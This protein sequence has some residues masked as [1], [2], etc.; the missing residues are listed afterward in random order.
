VLA[1]KQAGRHGS[2]RFK[3]E[4]MI[5]PCA[6]QVQA[7]DVRSEPF[8]VGGAPADCGRQVLLDVRAKWKCEDEG[9][10]R[11][12]GKRA[13]AGATLE[14]HDAATDALLGTVQAD[15]HGRFRLPIAAS[16]APSAI[17]PVV[18]D[19]EQTWTVEPVPVQ[20]DTCS[21]DEEVRAR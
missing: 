9:S 13:L 5:P 14:V 10:L 6:V 17:K 7:G 18:S 8:P 15:A 2:F 16:T 11:V 19:G 3:L 21:D 4:P 12:K 1:S 20:L